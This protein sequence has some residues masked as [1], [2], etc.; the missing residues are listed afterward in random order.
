M[1][2][3]SLQR[4]HA[5]DWRAEWRDAIVD[6]RELLDILGLQHL[7]ASLPMQI[8]PGFGLRVPRAFVRRMRRGDPMDPL[9]RQV[10]PLREESDPVAGF[11]MDPVG[12]LTARIDDGAGVLQKYAGRALLIATGSCAVHCRYCFR[13]HFPYSDE[14]AA[15][16][17][18]SDAL[19]TVRQDSSL[20]EVILS[21]GDPLSL[22]TARL[23]PLTTGLDGI[24]H[25]RTLR[26]HTRLPVVLPARVDQELLD[27]LSS[28]RQ[29][30]VV[31]IHANH[32]Q[33]IDGEVADALARLRGAG[34]VLLNQSVLLR[35]VNDSADTLAALSERLLD[36]DVLPYY[37]HTL[38]AVA[39]AAHFAVEN[40]VA[41]QLI[42]SLRERLP[43]YLVPRLVREV[44]GARSKLP[45]A[46][47]QPSTASLSSAE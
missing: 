39:G 15:R 10:L 22:A 9:L 32:P 44:E 24:A 8:Q 25:V 19:D 11:V 5:C 6:A 28:L 47:L 12:D 26:I 43:G 34:C 14:L 46:D 3:A 23:V 36:C 2:P 45:L 1:I 40:R 18:W 13:R 30:R 20:R 41:L 7:V 35:G 27:W 4:P 29:R 38:D 21:G 31:V 42:E 17:A 37:L 33:E 16:F